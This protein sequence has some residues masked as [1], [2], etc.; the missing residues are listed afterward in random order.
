MYFLGGAIFVGTFVFAFKAVMGGLSNKFIFT[1]LAV[2][3]ICWLLLVNTLY[4]S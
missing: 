4:Y 1:S 3:T 2:L